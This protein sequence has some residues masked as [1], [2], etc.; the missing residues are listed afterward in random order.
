MLYLKKKRICEFCKLVNIPFQIG[1]LYKNIASRKRHE[2]QPRE[3]MT[4]YH[5]D[6]MLNELKKDFYETRY[7]QSRTL[8]R[9]YR[10]DT[11]RQNKKPTVHILLQ[12][13]KEAQLCHA[14]QVL[15]GPVYHIRFNKSVLRSDI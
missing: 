7:N 9:S 14:R 3:P 13:T 8:D 15:H 11:Q 6:K 10:D 2:R 4:K 5:H 12:R 1:E